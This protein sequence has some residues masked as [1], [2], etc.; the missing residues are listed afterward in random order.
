MNLDKLLSWVKNNYLL[1]FA[2]W[3]LLLGG[4]ALLIVIIFRII[5]HFG[6]KKDK[7]DV[8]YLTE[9]VDLI[10]GKVDTMEI[11]VDSALVALNEYLNNLPS[12]GNKRIKSLFD[13]GYRA[14]RKCD[15]ST[16]IKFFQK[17]LNYAKGEEF[18]TLQTLIANCY[19][20]RGYLNKALEMYNSVLI[21]AQQLNDIRHK[22]VILGNIGLIHLMKGHFDD[23]KDNFSR[24]L[25]LA[26]E[27]GMQKCI[28]N[29]HGN[30]GITYQVEGKL[31]EAL[32]KHEKALAIA[33]E[34]DY[35]EAIAKRHCSIA[36]VYQSLGKIQCAI[37]NVKKG[38]AIA[39]AQNDKQTKIEAYNT[40]GIIYSYTGEYEVA[41]ENHKNALLIA[42]EIGDRVSKA[43]QL[44]N[45]GII[46]RLRKQFDEAL[47]KE[48]DVLNI[49]KSVGSKHGIVS[50]MN[51]IAMILMERGIRDRN[52]RDIKESAIKF[53]KALSLANEMNFISTKASILNNIGILYWFINKPDKAQQCH[54]E[55][56]Q[57]NRAMGNRNG[58][59]SALVGMGM[60]FER[61]GDLEKALEY[62]QS[63][64]TIFHQIGSKAKEDNVQQAIES[65]KNKIQNN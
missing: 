1:V 59:G 13:K 10:K 21:I 37:K 49:F 58:E 2:L 52:K 7:Q 38:M 29:Q 6:R 50:A 30:L 34:I 5:D 45:I 41:L 46:Y 33:R 51:G 61:K 23:A 12:T 4:L 27:Q 35:Q 14:K 63:A 55:V 25:M 53:E 26:E 40:M 20:A 15:L 9:N 62:Y 36:L 57:L 19:L 16:A 43:N 28:V 3:Q 17:A 47:E 56:L 48:K 65:L 18:V 31:K 42:E 24:S 8:R 22:T 54:E 60:V 44:G 64:W 11:K 39:I 32:N